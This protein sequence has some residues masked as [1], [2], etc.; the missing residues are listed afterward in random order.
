MASSGCC[1]TVIVPSHRAFLHLFSG[2]G[3]QVY[4]FWFVNICQSIM[5]CNLQNQKYYNILVFIIN[6]RATDYISLQEW[7]MENKA[8]KKCSFTNLFHTCSL[9]SCIEMVEPSATLSSLF[10][11]SSLSCLHNS[12]SNFSIVGLRFTLIFSM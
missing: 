11:L 6:I 10:I 7:D 4:Y 2:F 12:S 5:H 8:I 1:W 9:L 3:A